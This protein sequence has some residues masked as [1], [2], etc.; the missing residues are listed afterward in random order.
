MIVI[1]SLKDRRLAG[2][3][4]F[5]RP[6]ADYEGAFSMTISPS[7]TDFNNNTMVES[8]VCQIIFLLKLDFIFSQR[9]VF[10][11]KKLIVAAAPGRLL[12]QKDYICRII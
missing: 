4:A 6:L 12:R 2:N 5:F 11:I 7:M 9:P 8:R 3:Q 1:T 10:L